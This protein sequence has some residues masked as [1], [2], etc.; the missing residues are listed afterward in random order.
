MVRR[1]L[2]LLLL[3]LPLLLV[4]VCE[5]EKELGDGPLGLVGGSICCNDLRCEDLKMMHS[6]VSQGWDGQV[7]GGVAVSAMVWYGLGRR[8]SHVS[9]SGRLDWQVPRE[10]L[11]G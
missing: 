2:L 9:A 4:M 11:Q 5:L 1:V 10:D 8:S 3:L 7:R 6:H